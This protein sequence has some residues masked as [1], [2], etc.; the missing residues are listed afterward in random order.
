[1][2]EEDQWMIV[3]ILSILVCTFY[4]PT[5]L[6]A[7]PINTIYLVELDGQTKLEESYKFTEWKLAKSHAENSVVTRS[8]AQKL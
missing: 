7:A 4:L 2:P 3:S 1:M 8:R 5:K 6:Q